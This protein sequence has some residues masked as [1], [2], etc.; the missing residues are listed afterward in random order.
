[1]IRWLKKINCTD[2]YRWTP[3]IRLNGRGVYLSWSFPVFMK[4]CEVL[5]TAVIHTFTSRIK[6]I[7]LFTMELV[8]RLFLVFKILALV[9]CEYWHFGVMCML[10]AYW[11]LFCHISLFF[12]LICLGFFVPVENFSIIWRRHHDR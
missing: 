9:I 2:H 3:L 8:I 5:S 1:M 10:I 11:Y 4:N 7:Q 12:V 6:S